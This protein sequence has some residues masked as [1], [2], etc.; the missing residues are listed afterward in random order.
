MRERWAR[1]LAVVTGILVIALSAGFA[2]IQNPAA[3][4]APAARMQA[5]SHPA[6]DDAELLAAG[7]KVYDAQGCARCHAIAG[8][9]SPR[10]PLDGVG[11]NLD[12]TQIRQ[13]VIGDPAI[14]DELAP[15]VLEAKRPYAALPAGDL[16][17]LVAYLA[18]LR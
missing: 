18:S 8:E 5:A 12:A 7:R 3:G 13:Y 4:V 9:G 10:S 6:A 14:A 11:G 2:W 17:A 1:W 15:R 16:D